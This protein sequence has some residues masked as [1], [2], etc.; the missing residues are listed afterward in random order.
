MSRAW[1]QGSTRRWRWIR[2]AVLVRDGYRCRIALPGTWPVMGGMARCLGVADCVHHTRGRALTG[3]DPAFM[4]AA[5][6]PCN[7]KVGD[8]TRMPDPPPRPMTRW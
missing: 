2:D 1:E 4:V 6:T 7:L 8:P 5:C 3:D